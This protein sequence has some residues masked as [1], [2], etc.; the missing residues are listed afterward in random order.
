MNPRQILKEYFGYDAFRDGQEQLIEHIL[1]GGDVLGIMPTGAG[2]SVCY[3]VPALML[4]GLTVVISPLISLMEDQVAT[5]RESGIPAVCLHSNLDAQQYADALRAVRSGQVRL[6]YAAPERLETE[7]FLSLAQTIP[8]AMLAVD[9]AHCLSQ[10][11]QDFRPSYLHILDFLQ[12]LPERPVVAAF[13]ATATETVRIDIKR[14]LGLRNPYEL[15]TGFDRRNLR[16]IV[17]KP[18]K[19][20]DALLH[21]LA[22]N[23]DKSGIIYC[24]SRRKTE[25]VCDMLQQKGYAVTR[26]HAGLSPEER[27]A[28]QEAFL[29]DEIPLIVATNAFGMGIDKSNV[30][31]VVH[32][33]MP[34]SME[35]YYQE[36]GRAGRDG[37]PAECTLLFGA[38]DVRINEMLIDSSQDNDAMTPEQREWVRRKDHERLQAMIRYCNLTDC[39]RHYIL[40]YFGETAVTYCGNCGSCLTETETIDATIPAQKILSCVYRLKQRERSCGAK[41][42]CEILTGKATKQ[43]REQGY[44]TLSTYGIMQDT[45]E[46]QLRHMVDIL[47]SRGYLLQQIDRMNTLALTAA[48]LPVLRGQETVEMALPKRDLQQTLR[49]QRLQAMPDYDM[50]EQLFQRLRKVRQKLA[51]QEYVPAYIVFSDATLRE[52]CIKRPTD[53]DAMLAISGV[54]K[55]KLEKYGKAF[56]DA[57]HEYA[58]ESV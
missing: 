42:I 49:E 3:Q 53:A 11:G 19:K 4:P 15:V 12:A 33:N 43:I 37:M 13:T 57:L 31:F 1:Q 2:K 14:L 5:L 46:Q 27:S 45:A 47:L 17:E 54:V 10:W 9:E 32:Y 25:E 26:Y 35:A 28:N 55:H 22:R 58:A 29:R 40:R 51:A 8:I 52:L 39:L 20:D 36:A 6:L 44:E 16:W 18:K 30:S 34:K 7:W 56:L 50:D 24:I 38:N 23:R 41:A 48:A 21:I